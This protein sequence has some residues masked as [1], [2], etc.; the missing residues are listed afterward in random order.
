MKFAFRIGSV[1]YLNAVPLTYGIESGCVFLPPSQL[2]I[3][4]HA[5]RL[6]AALVSVTE[7]LLHPG[8]QVL[9]GFGIL[10]RGSVR[11][12]FLAH[13]ERLEAIREIH[14][15]SASCTSINLLR[16]LLE[17][18]GLHP[19]FRPLPDYFFA[20]NL[21]NVLLIGNPALEFRE[22]SHA[23]TLWDLGE[24]WQALHQ[25]PF[26]Y[27]VWALPRQDASRRRDIMEHLRD[28]ANAGLKALSEIVRTHPDFSPE[29]RRQYLGGNIHY[30]LDAAAKEGLVTFAQSLGRCLKQ[31][32]YMPEYAAE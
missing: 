4:L 11:S 18:R 28:A 22:Q 5:G 26:V 7:V 13:R 1:P 9:D 32:I 8:Y 10:S 21:P 6:D 19:A 20:P 17:D 27:A 15:D 2:A 29:L 14:L 16:V 23:H 31:K 24:A 30:R 12:V 3:E 25:L